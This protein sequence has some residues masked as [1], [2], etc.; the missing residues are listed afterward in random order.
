MFIMSSLVPE[1]VLKQVQTF[2]LSS[3][4][5]EHVLKQVPGLPGYSDGHE[6]E[7]LA[8]GQHDEDSPQRATKYNHKI[9]ASILCALLVTFL[10]FKGAVNT[11]L[12]LYYAKHQLTHSSHT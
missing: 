2:S 9:Y 11:H 7:R 1:H 12:H 3:L 8:N 4:V 6:Y 10:A 5:P